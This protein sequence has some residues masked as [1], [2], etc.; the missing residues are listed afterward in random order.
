MVAQPKSYLGFVQ[1]SSGRPSP[2]D[3]TNADLNRDEKERRLNTLVV[4]LQDLGFCG[5]G[6]SAR[7]SS[8]IPAF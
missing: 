8:Q 6:R 2:S 1:A 7:S 4:Q 5:S 3:R